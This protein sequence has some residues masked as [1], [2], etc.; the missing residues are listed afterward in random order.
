MGRHSDVSWDEVREIKARLFNGFETQEVVAFEHGVSQ[1]LVSRIARGFA[2]Y[3]IPWPD[4]STGPLPA[5]RRTE[6]D[7]LKRRQRRSA[8]PPKKQSLYEKHGITEEQLEEAFHRTLIDTAHDESP[9]VSR[10]ELFTDNEDPISPKPKQQWTWE[11]VKAIVGDRPYIQY[12]EKVCDKELIDAVIYTLENQRSAHS[13]S[14]EQWARL[15]PTVA[16]QLA[17]VKK[18]DPEQK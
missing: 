1:A 16:I 13:W 2:H 3:D 6:K 5:Y 11:E 10:E 8:P 12:I 7:M 9:P 15:I 17:N 18:S 4:G 14:N